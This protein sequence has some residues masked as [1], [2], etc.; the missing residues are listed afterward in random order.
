MTQ[1]NSFSSTSEEQ[2]T[3]HWKSVID[4]ADGTS[5]LKKDIKSALEKMELML[6]AYDRATET[7]E[8]Y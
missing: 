6:V 1:K 3:A 2:I 5:N 7:N 8:S 4:L